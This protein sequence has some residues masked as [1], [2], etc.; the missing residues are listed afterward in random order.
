MESFT[1]RDVMCSRAG[2]LHH[3][4]PGRTPPPGTRKDST[5]RDT[6]RTPPPPPPGT[7]EDSTTRDPGGL[8]HPG[9]GRT[10]PLHHPGPGG[11]HPTTGTREDST[12]RD[13]G[14]L[15]WTLQDPPEIIPSPTHSRNL[16]PSSDVI[17]EGVRVEGEGVRGE[18][19][20]DRGEVGGEGRE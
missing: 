6:G 3:P 7:Q 9:P 8:H 12:T 20:G 14:G 18:G 2:A 19:E 13:P 15:H 17:T 11:L 1:S 16:T 5:T 4:G 10:P